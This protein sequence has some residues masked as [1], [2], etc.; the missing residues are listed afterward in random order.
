VAVETRQAAGRVSSPLV[1]F[2]AIG[3]LQVMMAYGSA[4]LCFLWLYFAGTGQWVYRALDWS[5]AVS[6]VFYTATPLLM[7]L[8]FAIMYGCWCFPPT[9]PGCAAWCFC[10]SIVKVTQAV[11][12]WDF[13]SARAAAEKCCRQYSSVPQPV[14][15][16]LVMV[17]R[18]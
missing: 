7:I 9:M 8:G 14:D 16:A 4:Y 1:A 10:L 11:L 2:A 12:G 18:I 15:L 13:F 6:P 3:N 17:L 5:L